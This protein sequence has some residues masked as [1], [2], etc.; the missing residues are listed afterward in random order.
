MDPPPPQSTTIAATSKLRLMCSYGGHITPRP[1]TKAL[2]YLGGETRIISVDITAVNTLSAF[3]SHL[4]TIL[5]I[6]PPFSLKYQLP[7]SALDSLISLSSDDDLHFML[8]EH[9]RLTSSTSSRIRLFV[10]FPEP[11]KAR[12]VIHH[13]KTEA[14]FVDALK[15]A[16]ILQKGQDCLVGFDAE[17]V[18][19]EN[20]AKGITD[21]GNGCVSL[22]ES[23]ILETNSS[24]GSS[25]S[26][27]SSANV[28]PPIKLQ[29]EDFG[30]S[31]PDNA[32]KQHTTSDSAATLVSEIAPTNSCCSVENAFS[33]HALASQLNPFQQ[34]PWQFVQAGT[35]M[36]SC[37]P[38][39]YPMPSYYPV[40]QPQFVHYQPMPN[41][42]MYPVYFLP[43][44]QTQVPPPSNLPMH[45]GFHDTATGS[46][47]PNFGA[48]PIAL[49][50]ADEAQEQAVSIGN[51]GA[52]D[53]SVEEGSHECNEDDPARTLI[54]KSQPGPPPL[55]PPSQSQTK[56]K[57]STNLLSDAMAQLQLI[58]IKQ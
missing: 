48:N 50:A 30:L 16:K 28:S 27:T 3:I 34:Q 8:C 51:Y 58:K 46:S 22:P 5:P 39:M 41:H 44:G 19:G 25:S 32:A 11:E 31:L 21:L 10:F 53:A 13:P 42:H 1:R 49:E 29:S 9:L 40:Q 45:W 57:G 52:A 43:V 2:S 37:L 24:F 55:V 35:P 33:G 14:W 17:G 56:T 12:N 54:Y 18:I 36:E 26:S 23:M 7:H 38:A 4:L 6:K 15:G 47:A 20:E